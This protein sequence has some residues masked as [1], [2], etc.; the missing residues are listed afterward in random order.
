MH[1]NFRN[2]I[3]PR[4]LVVDRDSLTPFYGKFI[5]EPLER[6]YGHTLGNSLRRILLGSLHGYAITS[7]RIK[8]ALHEFTALE[9]VVE[10]V[11]DIVLNLKEVRLRLEGNHETRTLRANCEGPCVVTAADLKGDSSV[12]ILN[13]D[14]VICH[15][16]DGGTFEGEFMVT[17]G[18]G[19]TPATEMENDKAPVGTIVIDALYSP[20]SKVN[21][22]VNHARVGQR[23]DYDKLVLEVWCDGTVGPEDSVGIAA[24]I[25]KEYAQLFI[26]FEEPETLEFELDEDPAEEMNA[27]LLRSVDELELS[28]RSMNCL[29]TANIK[30]IGDLVQKTEAE[31]LRTKNFGRKSLKEIKNVLAEMGLSLGM[32]LENWPPPNHPSLQ[33]PADAN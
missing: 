30:L 27:N 21:F 5:A 1:R 32:R 28:V 20:V 2:L 29:Q 3:K 18:K 31:M 15:V 10:D 17:V 16:A 14:H 19:Y 22:A 33:T 6:G 8:G 25:L 4:G 12:V 11:T 24:K 13:P 7:C 23:T 26:H 9:N